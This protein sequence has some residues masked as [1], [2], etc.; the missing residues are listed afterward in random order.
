MPYMPYMPICMP[1]MSD[2]CMPYMSECV[3]RRCRRQYRRPAPRANQTFVPI[4]PDT[5]RRGVR[6]HARFVVLKS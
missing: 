1:Y 6:H 5:V 3:L 4:K 2:I